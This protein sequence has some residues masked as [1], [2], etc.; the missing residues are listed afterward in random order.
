M[1]LSVA[2]VMAAGELSWDMPTG[3]YLQEKMTIKPVDNYHSM[4]NSPSFS[5]PIIYDATYELVLANDKELT[6]I[7]YEVKD[8]PVNVYTFPHTL[9]AGKDY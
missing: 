9:E 4:Q 8:I 7:A 1:L 5:W 3:Y 6:D 2:P